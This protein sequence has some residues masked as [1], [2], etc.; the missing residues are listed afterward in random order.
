MEVPGA[1][2]VCGD[3]VFADKSGHGSCE[4]CGNKFELDFILTSKRDVM[5]TVRT[6]VKH[7]HMRMQ[8]NQDAHE[9]ELLLQ[10]IR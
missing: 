9:S 10:E 5:P 1:C 4:T 3:V 2:E 7:G 6:S 8:V